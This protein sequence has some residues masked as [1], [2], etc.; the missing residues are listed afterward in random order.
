MVK[1]WFKAGEVP[2]NTPQVA[3]MRLG[4]LTAY[5]DDEAGLEA[6]VGALSKVILQCSKE[7]LIAPRDVIRHIAEQKGAYVGDRRYFNAVLGRCLRLG[8]LD[9]L[10]CGDPKKPF[11]CV[12]NP[13]NNEAI[14]LLFAAAMNRLL[15]QPEVRVGEIRE[16][17]FPGKEWGTW[18]IVQNAFWRLVYLGLARPGE[19]GVF[20]RSEAL[21]RAH[22]QPGWQLPNFRKWWW[23]D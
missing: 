15:A 23:L 3:V 20:A 19:K 21:K 9:T 4:G 7:H 8:D 11:V 17:A 14:E 12:L 13:V 1:M 18:F 22:S 6:E 10:T 16:M 5:S 2:A